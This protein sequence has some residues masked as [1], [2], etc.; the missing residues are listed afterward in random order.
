MRKIR[1]AAVAIAVAM[2]M[3]MLMS[4]QA[5]R[6]RAN[7]VKADD[8]WYETTKFELKKDIHQYE[9]VAEARICTSNDKVF[10]LY[11]LS[12]DKWGSARTVLDTYDFEGNLISRKELSC[13]EDCF[14][15]C[16]YSISSDPEGKT[17]K[18]AIF[19]N[20]GIG[21][22]YPAFADINTETGEVTNIKDM[23]NKGN[24][25]INEIWNVSMIGEYAVVSVE[26]SSGMP[27]GSISPL[28]F[29]DSELVGALD[30]STLNLNVIFDTFSLDQ[31]K[32]SLYIV[33]VENGSFIN[34]EFDLNSGRLK[35]KKSLQDTDD[36]TLSLLDFTATDL[37]DLCRITSMGR[38]EKYDTNNM[39]SKLMVDSTWYTPVFPY[40][41]SETRSRFTTILSCTDER[42]VLLDSVQESYGINNPIQKEYITVL[43]KAEKNPHAGKQII[44]IAPSAYN[45]GVSDYLY[46]AISEFNKTDNEYLIRLWDKSNTDESLAEVVKSL[47]NGGDTPAYK[48][49]QE[50]KGNE[51]PDLVIDVQNIYAMRDDIFMDLTGFLEPEVMDKQYKN[52][53]E[54][55]TV[56]GKLYFLPVTLKIEGMVTNTDLLKD[57]AAGITFDEFEKMIKEDLNG[58]S[59]YDLPNKWYFNKKTFIM[60]CLDT[61]S[62][63]EGDKVDFGTEQFKRAVD[64]AKENFPYEDELSV[65]P[66]Y[67]FDWNLRHRSE[68][69]YGEISC[70]LDFV[71][72]CKTQKGNYVIIGTPSEDAAGPRF[73]S[74]ETISVSASTDVKEGC[75]KFINF[76]FSGSAFGP[77][78]CGFLSIVTNKEI[79]DRNI[80]LLAKYNND[81]FKLYRASVESGATIPA[82]GVEMAYGVKYST[83]EMQK[84]FLNSMSTISK[85]YYEDPEITRFIFEEIAPY[86]AGDRSMDDVIKILN[87]RATKYIKE[88]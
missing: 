73:K 6:N 71:K 63:I 2:L 68:C 85:Y 36:K 13:S 60:S 7:V 10:S 74:Q 1:F 79:M 37:G 21:K 80:E 88:M 30:T 28:L 87:D 50:L 46:R 58:Y 33:C 84:S 69:C 18:T 9:Q 20:Y 70:Y 35:S 17:L 66:E 44:E 51:A 53:I 81:D 31:A 15:P 75:K 76:L 57:G 59:P 83:D 26:D 47:G 39:T 45:Y 19:L 23:L 5:R 22:F 49:I 4:C 42:T 52:I 12:Q 67:I 77:D 34:V 55:G 72:M 48:M 43:K 38:V 65:P 24:T 29:K 40:D 54:A 32:G 61:K 11:P 25:F 27:D 3:P 16:V 56:N 62:A 41:S 78:D 14:F 86:Y 82:P 64:Y 8:P